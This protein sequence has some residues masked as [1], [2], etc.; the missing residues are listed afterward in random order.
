MLLIAAL[1]RNS[2]FP[3]AASASEWIRRRPPCSLALAATLDQFLP[4]GA[5]TCFGEEALKKQHLPVA[6]SA[7][8]WIRRRPP[9]SLAL[10][11][12]LRRIRRQDCVLRARL[13]GNSACVVATSASEWIRR[14]FAARWRS[15]PLLSRGFFPSRAKRGFLCFF[16][17]LSL[18]GLSSRPAST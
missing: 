6:A 2:T 11:A 12:T 3:V 16:C 13:L 5:K 1:L 14:R 7:S 10:A 15:Q 18:P 4:A 17:E 8:E 9:C